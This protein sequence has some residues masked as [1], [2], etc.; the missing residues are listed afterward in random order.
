MLQLR[1]NNKI[2]LNSDSFAGRYWADCWRSTRCGQA[3]VVSLARGNVFEGKAG[4]PDGKPEVHAVGTAGAQS[5]KGR[6]R[7]QAAL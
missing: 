2:E 4:R 3:D 1:C 5:K 7:M 6:L